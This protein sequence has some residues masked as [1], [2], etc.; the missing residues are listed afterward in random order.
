MSGLF[1]DI[2]TSPGSRRTPDARVTQFLSHWCELWHRRYGT[3][4]I[5]SSPA[6]TRAII[7]RCLVSLAQAG[8]A[9]ALADMQ[10]AARRLLG[11]RLKWL[12]GCPT[13][14]L[15]TSHVNELLVDGDGERKSKTNWT[16]VDRRYSKPA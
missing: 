11:G 6:R 1:P 7:K 9:N 13:I 5:D 2:P 10:E 8:R 15:L 16:E 14:G 4:W 12:E 3:E